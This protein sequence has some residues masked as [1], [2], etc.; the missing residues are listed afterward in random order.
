MK[1]IVAILLAGAIG[2]LALTYWKASDDLTN[3]PILAGYIAEWATA[4]SV[5][6]IAVNAIIHTPGT[7]EWG[8][9]FESDGTY[10]VGDGGTS[11]GPMQV[12][13]GGAIDQY[14]QDMGVT[15][16]TSQLSNPTGPGAS[17]AVQIGVH[18]LA[19]CIADANGINPTAFSNYNAGV[20]NY[21]FPN[22]S[23]YGNNA[24][25]YYQSIGGK[26]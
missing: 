15:V 26:S 7:G 25:A 6:P 22:A 20:G 18:Y 13:E 2:Y 10:P 24:Y 14:E 11:F 3:N 21:S 8:G 16:D 23:D 17:Q 4:Y 9:G 19:L 12:H 5:D 1:W